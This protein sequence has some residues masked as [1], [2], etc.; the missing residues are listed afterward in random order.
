V[1]LSTHTARVAQTPHGRT[2]CNRYLS[3]AT[4]R[5]W[6]GA[7]AW[8]TVTL[9]GAPA[10]TMPAVICFPP[11]RWFAKRSRDER[12]GW[13][14]SPL[15]RW[16]DVVLSL[17]LTIRAQR[18]NPYPPHYERAFASSAILYPQA[19]QRPSRL[20]FLL[21]YTG[22]R[23]MGLTRSVQVPAWV[24]LRLSA[25]GSPSAIGELGAPI[26]DPSPFGPSL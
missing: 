11:R 9:G 10:R 12:P 13:E 26:P 24:R 17:T 1:R 20:A 25:G 5:Y 15:S 2:R 21:R 19:R 18:L 4:A 16:D 7:T 3:A 8:T 14:V 23:P 6:L 22:G